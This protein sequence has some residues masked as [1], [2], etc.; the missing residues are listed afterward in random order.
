MGVTSGAA[1]RRLRSG[2]SRQIAEA[3]P[4][5]LKRLDEA[6]MKRFADLIAN[7][8]SVLLSAFELKLPGGIAE[9]DAYVERGG[10]WL[11]SW[12]L[13]SEWRELGASLGSFSTQSG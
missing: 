11:I 6:R 5:Q 7:N 9:R 10:G 1:Q 13:L 4:S 3:L 12:R 8:I 2:L